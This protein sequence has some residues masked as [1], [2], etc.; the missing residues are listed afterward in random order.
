MSVVAATVHVVDDDAAVRNALARLLRAAGHA[1]AG[2]PSGEAFLAAPASTVPACIL[3]DIGLPG[4]D[5]FTVQRR[6][7]DAGDPRPVV[8]LTAADQVLLSVRAMKAGAVDYLVKPVA[9]AALL[10]AVAEALRRSVT[11][12]AAATTKQ[13]L[14]ARAA[15][16]TAREREV[17]RLVI[18]GLPN[19]RIARVLG[20]AEKTVKIHRG[21]V[22]GKMQADSLADLVRQGALLDVHAHAAAGR[23]D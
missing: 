20:I 14:A 18:A 7:A 1:V 9:A 12:C 11:A 15:D 16:L 19:K 22:M 3:L 5:G 2:W 13:A 23:A 6:L 8:F 4:C 17:M 10:P 21:R